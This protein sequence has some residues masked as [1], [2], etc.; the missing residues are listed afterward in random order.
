MSHNIK[1]SETREITKMD[2]TEIARRLQALEDV[3]AIKQLKN[4][5]CRFCD[6]GYDPDGIASCF[7]Q[8]AVWEAGSF[9]TYNG[10]EAIR[11]FVA[12]A[13]PAALSFAMHLVISPVIE[14]MGDKA[15]GQWYVFEPVTF[16]EGQKA[17]W[18]AGTYEN[19]FVRVD[20]EWK[21]QR[22]RFKTYLSTTFDKPWT[23]RKFGPA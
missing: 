13:A 9:G 16:A 5:Y 14:V 19:D 12:K 8:D 7:V 6:A 23:N 15:K 2:L 17:G 10:R 11:D 21:F 3:E 4:R 22:L 20:G 18:L 1:Q